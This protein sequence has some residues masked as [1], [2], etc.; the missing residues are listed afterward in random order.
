MSDEKRNSRREGR[1]VKLSIYLFRE[2]TRAQQEG[3]I[4]LINPPNNNKELH[5]NYL[6]EIPTKVREHLKVI[7]L[8]YDVAENSDNTVITPKFNKR[9]VI[10]KIRLTDTKHKVSGSK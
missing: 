1:M 4:H 8:T 5:F 10:Q 3:V 7:G 6:D 2:C 9:K